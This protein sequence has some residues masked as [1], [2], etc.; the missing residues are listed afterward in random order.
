MV[1]IHKRTI[2]EALV[3]FAKR[4]QTLSNFYSRVA[5]YARVLAVVVC[6]CVCLSLSVTRRY[7]MKTVKHKITQRTPCDSPGTLVF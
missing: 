6:L 2:S 3:G 4:Y 5:S 1:N 7:C